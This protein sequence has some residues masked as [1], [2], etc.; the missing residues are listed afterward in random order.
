MKKTDVVH[1]G[2]CLYCKPGSGVIGCGLSRSCYY[3]YYI[4]FG[5][6][7][8]LTVTDTERSSHFD[9]GAAIWD[10]IY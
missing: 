9:G 4:P 5:F 6:S 2:Y 3:Y 8:R 7:G 10:I 1:R